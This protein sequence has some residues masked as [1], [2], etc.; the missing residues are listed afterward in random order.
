MVTEQRSLHI[1]CPSLFKSPLESWRSE[2]FRR[3]RCLFLLAT[4]T[5]AWKAGSGATASA[6]NRRAPMRYRAS[7]QTILFSWWSRVSPL[8]QAPVSMSLNTM[9][10]PTPLMDAASMRG[11]VAS[12]SVQNRILG[13]NKSHTFVVLN[14]KSFKL[15]FRP[16]LEKLLDLKAGTNV[17][18]LVLLRHFT[19]VWTWI[20]FE[21]TA[22]RGSRTLQTPLSHCPPTKGDVRQK[23]KKSFNLKSHSDDSRTVL[24]GSIPVP[25]NN[26]IRWIRPSWSMIHSFKWIQVIRLELLPWT[27][28]APSGTKSTH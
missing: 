22:D 3:E 16:H 10:R 13:S 12:Q 28:N 7:V 11:N 9:C 6:Q 15:L 20:L 8:G 1:W 23:K 26:L 14:S 17:K 2:S 24:G 27:G 19:K 4:A 21:M 5:P 18:P 25:I